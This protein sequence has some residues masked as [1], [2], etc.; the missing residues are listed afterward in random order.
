MAAHFDKERIIALQSESGSRINQYRM[1][2]YRSAVV[3]EEEFQTKSDRINE[4]RTLLQ[5]DKAVDRIATD[6]SRKVSMI[7]RENMTVTPGD[8]AKCLA[9]FHEGTPI[10][11]KC[12]DKPFADS[13]P[14]PIR[15]RN[16]ELLYYKD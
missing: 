11:E 15:R 5:S 8:E 4:A 6:R 16:L 7:S 14:N 9:T 2:P 10:L 3:T 13:V 12:K 1:P